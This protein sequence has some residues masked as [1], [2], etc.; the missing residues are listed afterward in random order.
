MGSKASCWAL[1]ASPVRDKSCWGGRFLGGMEKKM[2][3]LLSTALN[4]YLP[5]GGSKEGWRERRREEGTEGQEGRKRRLKEV[6]AGG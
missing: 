2:G 4:N 6:A 5:L 3:C 1:A